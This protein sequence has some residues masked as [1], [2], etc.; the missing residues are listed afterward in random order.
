MKRSRSDGPVT[1]Q[2][3]A[4]AAGVSLATA[5][6]S[7]HN[8]TRAPRPE[9][10]ERVQRAAADLGYTS[11]G[12]AQAL[13]RATTPVVGLIVHDI[14][15]PYFSA[16]AIGAMRV[17]HEHSLLVLVGNTF[18]NPALEFD[19]LARL[20]AQRARGVLLLASGFSGKAYRSALHHEL[21]ALE[22][23]GGRIACVSDHGIEADSVLPEH[24]DGARQV[25]DHLVGLGHERIAV[26][27]GPV[28]LLVSRERLQGFRD[29]LRAL[30]A[31]LDPTR[32]VHS[33]FTRDGGRHATLEL[34]ERHPDVTAVFA[35]NDMMAVGALVAL[36]DDLGRSVP[37]DVSVVG[38]DDVPLT[39]DLH[40]PLTTVHLPLE[41]IGEHGMRFLLGDRNGASTVRVPAR[42]LERGSSGPVSAPRRRRSA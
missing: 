42:L 14:T 25:A 4:T 6:R 9:L 13:A 20:R 28:N 37:D 23:L 21:A 36:R 12:P 17:A 32:V 5:S 22:A 38:F 33:D 26:V 29:R 19:Y 11:N 27:T 30:G 35:L 3:V 18:R 16:L 39:R 1:L 15:D 10:R 41:E 7:L 31:P 40:P 2:D 8:G 24:R 34:M